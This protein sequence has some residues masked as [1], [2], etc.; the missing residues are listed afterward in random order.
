MSRSNHGTILSSAHEC[1]QVLMG[2]LECSCV[3][4]SAQALDSV[5]NENVNFTCSIL[6]IFRSRLHHIIMGWIIF[7][8]ILEGAVK[9][10]PRSN[11]WSPMKLRISINKSGNSLVDTL[12]NQTS[13]SFFQNYDHG[14][15]VFE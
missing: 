6:A 1:L 15:H 10:C 14:V 11:F 5:I 2:S 7:K 3:I 12:Y 13:S 8:S 9:K 4:F